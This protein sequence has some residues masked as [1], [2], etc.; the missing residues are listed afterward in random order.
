MVKVAIFAIG[1]ELL[2][3]SIVDTNSSWL[4]ARLTK[5]GF[6]VD[7]VRLIPDNKE[8][9]V[10]ILKKSL[11]EYDVI[12]T[13]GGI[14]PTFDD[15]TAET[16]AEAAGKVTVMNPEARDHMIKWLNKR[17]VTIKESHERQALLPADCILFKNGSGTAF[18]FGVEAEN[19]IIISMPGVPY[20]MHKMFDGYVKP[21]L[22]E[23]FELTERF[24]KDVRI[25]GL[26]ES[27]IDDVVR[28][29]NIP[30]G[31]EC[32]INVSKGECLV[33]FRG[34]IQSIVEE[35]ADKLA[36]SFPDN[37][38]GFGNDGL[39]YVLLRLLRE[40]KMTLAVAESCTGGMLG[41]ELT[42][43]SG[44][45]DVFMGGIISYSNDVKE[46]LLRV[47]KNIMVKHGAVSEETAKAMAIGA[48]NQIRTSCAISITGVAGPDGGTEEKPVGTVC[49]G[50]C[51]NGEVTTKSF[52]FPG[53]RDAV[54]TRAL[55]TALREMIELIKNK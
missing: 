41:K 43:V 31:L 11:K 48:A 16:V 6:N 51:V 33:K 24:S 32:I 42:E 4:G 30:N 14:G 54:R 3:G 23:R 15:L 17:G 22:L 35:Y 8:R 37:F 21:Y 28:E 19:C 45:S 55:K 53:Y 52:Q 5:A 2:E 40:K 20:E 7:D 10:N 36:K 12:L 13:T 29:L 49:I 27:D 18:G 1:S 38:V 25:A 50:Y 47:P 46:R 9:I 44:S 26:P 39:A 34:F